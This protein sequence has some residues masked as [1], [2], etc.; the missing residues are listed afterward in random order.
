MVMLS[1]VCNGHHSIR[2]ES[3]REL[4]FEVLKHKLLGLLVNGVRNMWGLRNPLV[5]SSTSTSMVGRR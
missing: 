4:N 2:D 1:E 5:E 3:E